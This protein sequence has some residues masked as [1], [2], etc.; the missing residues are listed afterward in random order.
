[1]MTT[2]TIMMPVQTVFDVAL[3]LQGRIGPDRHRPEVVADAQVA[4]RRASWWREAIG[5][6]VTHGVPRP[7][8]R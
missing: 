5:T 3:Q 1:M 7:A 2:H 6:S 8:R 4:G